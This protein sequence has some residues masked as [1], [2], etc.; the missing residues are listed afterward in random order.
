MNYEQL[1]NR[2]EELF[3]NGNLGEHIDVPCSLEDGFESF[4]DKVETLINQ[5]EVIYYSKAIEYLMRYDVSLSNSLELAA[6]LGY[7]L[8]D[9][10]LNSEI[11][12]T[13]FLQNEL[14]DEFYEKEDDIE[15]LFEEFEEE[16]EE[17]EESLT[18]YPDDIVI[19]SNPLRH[20]YWW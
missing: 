7:S 5:T 12:A 13:L 14:R 20:N 16:E 19:S 17:E 3:N 18:P 2:I 9:G 15:E 11:L 1:E 4:R 10:N 6:E 8:A